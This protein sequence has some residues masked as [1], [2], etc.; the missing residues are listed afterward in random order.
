MNRHN[1]VWTEEEIATADR[2][3][4]GGLNTDEIGRALGRSESAVRDMFHRRQPRQVEYR[5]GKAIG[6]TQ[7]DRHFANDARNGSAR[8]L[9]EIERVFG[10]QRRMAA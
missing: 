2:L 3:K 1:C 7:E 8:L 9:A 6:Q 5:L 10:P 4:D